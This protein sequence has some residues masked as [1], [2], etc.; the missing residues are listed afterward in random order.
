MNPTDIAWA[1]VTLNWQSGCTLAGPECEACYAEKMSQRLA[2]M[3]QDRY[4]GATDGWK[5]TGAI[6]YDPDALHRAFDA[7]EKRKRPTR[8]F[9]GSMT[10]LWHAD[11][12]EAALYDLA[13]RIDH[14]ALIQSPH[15]VMALTK[16]APRL[17]SWQRA[18]FPNGLPPQVWA[19]VTAGNQRSLD[20]RLPRLLE[21][22]AETRFVSVEPMLG[23]VSF[24]VGAIGPSGVRWV[25][26]GCE[27]LGGRA[28]RPMNLDW[29][30]GIKN[31]CGWSGGAFFFKQAVVDG[32]V[33]ETPELDGQRWMQFPLEVA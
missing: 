26:V 15:R 19:G 18:Y 6:K 5:W 28:G 3:G 1:D 32:A 25:I 23:P 8:A 2:N 24:P 9:I 11:A 30:R 22:R 20:L 27:S 17:L 21:L 14:L 29:V 16:R 7:L 13:T 12:P 4:V 31:Q 10:D 33:V